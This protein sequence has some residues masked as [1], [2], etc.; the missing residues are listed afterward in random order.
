MYTSISSQD[1]LVIGI[2][3]AERSFNIID[4]ELY[5]S[6]VLSWTLIRY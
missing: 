3:E 4:K 6:L 2:Y 1:T 5:Y